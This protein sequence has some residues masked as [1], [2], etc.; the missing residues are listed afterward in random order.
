MCSLLYVWW[1]PIIIVYPIE[2]TSLSKMKQLQLPE[3]L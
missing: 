3:H 2:P 1:V